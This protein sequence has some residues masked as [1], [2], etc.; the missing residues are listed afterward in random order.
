[1]TALAATMEQARRHSQPGCG[2]SAMSVSM[3]PAVCACLF[4][5][6][7]LVL[8]HLAALELPGLAAVCVIIMILVR[9]LNPNFTQTEDKA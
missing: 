2:F 3:G 5:F 8:A 9:V 7:V 6:S 4:L 1:M